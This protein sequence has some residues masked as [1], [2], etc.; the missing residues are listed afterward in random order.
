MVD[1]SNKVKQLRRPTIAKHSSRHCHYRSTAE[2]I[3]VGSVAIADSS[4]KQFLLIQ[5]LWL[6]QTML[7]RK[8][9]WCEF[10]SRS[11]GCRYGDFNFHPARLDFISS[12]LTHSVLLDFVNSSLPH[13]VPLDFVNSSLPH[14][15][16]FHFVNTPL[17]P[18]SPY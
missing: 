8:T 7:Y 11:L 16:P 14:S 1:A 6:I 4:L 2:A 5:L 13:Y 10:I 12:S 9:Q 15:V 3:F 17:P 18:L